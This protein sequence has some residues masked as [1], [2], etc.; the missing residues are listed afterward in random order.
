MAI[1][2]YELAGR[3]DRRFS[4]YCW[5]TRMALA[6]KGL[7]AEF[8]PWHFSEKEKIAFSGQG[9]VPVLVDGEKTVADS[10][11]IACYLEDRYPDRPALFGAAAARPLARFLNHFVDLVAH[12]GLL[13][14]II[15]DVYVHLD[16]ADQPYF[17]A[18][19]EE[20]FGA[21]LE[22]IQAGRDGRLAAWRASLEPI[23][24]Q[25]REQPFVAGQSPAY[26]DHIVF[27]MFGWARAISPYVLLER[28]DPLFAWR[29]R[30]MAEAGGHARALPGYPL[31]A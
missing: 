7:P 30:M 2:V 22:D 5:R 18:S 14:L 11:H 27:G 19:R 23:R 17:R 6:H 1:I 28:D 8:R 24:A 15:A 13:R 10:W 31:A 3:D 4:P 16:P 29:E 26:A 9:R 20:R 21:K 25:L 12:P